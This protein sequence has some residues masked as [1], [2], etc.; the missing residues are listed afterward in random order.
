MK[1]HGS[2]VV[3]RRFVHKWYGDGKLVMFDPSDTISGHGD[4]SAD[5]APWKDQLTL[6]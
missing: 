4:V 1:I 5:L 6:K 3:F 2:L